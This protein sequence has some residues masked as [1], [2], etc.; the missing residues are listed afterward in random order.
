V[1]LDA[2]DN[3]AAE[4]LQELSHGLYLNRFGLRAGEYRGLP[5]AVRAASGWEW[6]RDIGIVELDED[7]VR[8][9]G[10]EGVDDVHGGAPVR[11][12]RSTSPP[13]VEV[14]ALGGS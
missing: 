13:G 3:S 12:P 14:K 11:P 7:L 4:L 2:V 5:E 1:V 6:R 9:N 8:G 10:L